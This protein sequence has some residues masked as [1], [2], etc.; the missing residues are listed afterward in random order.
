MVAEWGAVYLAERADDLRCPRAEF[1]RGKAKAASIIL[2]A[3]AWEPARVG[4]LHVCPMTTGPVPHMGGP[5]LPPR[6]K[7]VLIGASGRAHGR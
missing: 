4:D 1:L 3:V 7:P 2:S 6:A 5:I